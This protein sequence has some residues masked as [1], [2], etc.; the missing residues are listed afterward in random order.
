VPSFETTL[1]IIARRFIA[2]S[3]LNTFM[4]SFGLAGVYFPLS[5]TT[6]AKIEGLTR[7]PSFAI[8]AKTD[9]ACIAVTE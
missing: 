2:V 5:S 9:V 1:S 6:P 4:D 8:V 3:A 7:T